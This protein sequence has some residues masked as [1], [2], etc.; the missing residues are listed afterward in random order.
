[1]LPEIYERYSKWSQ[2]EHG[3]FESKNT[4]AEALRERGYKEDRPKNLTRFKLRI[5]GQDDDCE[6]F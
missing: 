5:R 4:L 1:L 2:A 6:A 3:S